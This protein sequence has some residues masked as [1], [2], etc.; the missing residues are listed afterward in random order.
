MY[1]NCFTLL[2]GPL[3]FPII[4]YNGNA[5]CYDAAVCRSRNHIICYIV[6]RYHEFAMS[7][8]GI[9]HI[10]L[11][12]NALYYIIRADNNKYRIM[13]IFVGRKRSTAEVWFACVF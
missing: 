11:C 6:V 1:K 4:L 13:I 10:A 7:I 2:G 12:H 8:T 3:D 5:C 9:R